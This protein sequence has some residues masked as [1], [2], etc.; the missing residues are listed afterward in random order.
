VNRPPAERETGQPF[1]AAAPAE[2]GD[3]RSFSLSS[4]VYMVD[5]PG[6]AV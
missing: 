6:S 3:L 5:S 2:N 4:G 1:I